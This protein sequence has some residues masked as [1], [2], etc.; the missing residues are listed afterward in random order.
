MVNQSFCAK[1]DGAQFLCAKLVFTN[2]SVPK[3][4][5]IDFAYNFT[6]VLNY[7]LSFVAY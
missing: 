5:S 2:L 1:S 3:I 4:F 6:K 7:D